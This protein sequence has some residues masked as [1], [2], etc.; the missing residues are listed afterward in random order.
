MHAFD[1]KMVNGVIVREAKEGEELLTLEGETHKIAEGSLLICDTNNTPVAIA[2]IKGGKL[3]GISDETT[4]FLLESAV[5][6]SSAIRKTSKAIGLVTDASLRYEKSLDPEL[7]TLAIARLVKLLSDIDKDIVITS[8]V[9][10]VRTAEPKEIKINVKPSFIRAK[11]GVEAITDEFIESTLKKLGFTI[12]SKN[13]D[14]MQILVPSF[15]ATKDISIKEDIVEEVARLYGY[16]NIVPETLKMAVHPVAQDFSHIM[17]YKT[18]RLLAEKY[19]FSEVHSY[20]WNYADYNEAK[21]I[22]TKS[23]VELL[24][25]SN[26]G[27]SGLR[28]EMLPSLIKFYDENRNS[29]DEIRLVEIGRV[30]TGLDSNNLAIEEKHLAMVMA[31]ATKSEKELYFEMKRIVENLCSSLSKQHP[32][33]TGETKK[34]LYHPNMSTEVLINGENVGSFGVMH[35]ELKAKFDKK[36]NVTILEFDFNKFMVENA[37]TKT[38]KPVSK[39]QSVDLDFNFLVP[40]NMAFSDIEKLVSEFRCK[41]NVQYK[42]IDVYES[43]DFEG[44]RSET[45]R[46]TICSNEH[47]LSNGEIESFTKRITDH[48]KTASIN[49]R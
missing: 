25:S 31:S 4:G 1:S 20:I 38:Y 19:G 43:K 35:P 15:R 49:L 10:D 9:G 34:E 47:T 40:K 45:I 13:D 39:Y 8:K 14:E 23:F 41:F 11:I 37:E 17:E 28:C 30:V 7:T 33:Y 26:S 12:L 6:E 2:G 29:F 27:Q 3:S 16:D 22:K 18:K 5:F 42:L 48:F 32:I 24:D 36:E 44:F 46:F 21:G